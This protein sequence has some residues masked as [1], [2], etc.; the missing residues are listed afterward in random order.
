MIHVL[1]KTL[2]L[3]AM[4]LLLAPGAAI[5]APV[6]TITDLGGL[7]GGTSYSNAFAVNDSGQVAGFGIAAGGIRAFVWDSDSGMT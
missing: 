3:A 2:R 1:S 5:A 4:A 7:G 6:Y